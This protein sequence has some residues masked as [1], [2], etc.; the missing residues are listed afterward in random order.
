MSS[1]N[2]GTAYSKAMHLLAKSTWRDF[3]LQRVLCCWQMTGQFRSDQWEIYPSTQFCYMDPSK[4]WRLNV[5]N[6]YCMKDA[7]TQYVIFC[8][9][10]VIGSGLRKGC[11]ILIQRGHGPLRRCTPAAIFPIDGL[12]VDASRC[13]E[14]A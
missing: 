6:E 9:F 2:S 14:A 13:K 8:L 3:F 10:C 5:R 7:L 4:K 11:N 1:Q 12:T